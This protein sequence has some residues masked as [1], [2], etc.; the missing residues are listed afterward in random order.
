[1]INKIKL[2]KYQLSIPIKDNN[3]QQLEQQINSFLEKWDKYKDK[4]PRKN[5][6]K[7]K[8]LFN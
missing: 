4:L 2:K 7:K 3:V 1:L 8:I 5:L 6:K